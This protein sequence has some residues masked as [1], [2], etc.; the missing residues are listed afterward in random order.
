MPTARVG[1]I[2]AARTSRAELQ[3]RV[4]LLREDNDY[5]RS[6]LAVVQGDLDRARATRRILVAGALLI[7][8]AS[9]LAGALV[10]ALVGR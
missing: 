10:T 8:A 1:D 7:V 9:G 4:A 3:E 5:L 6:Q 2:G